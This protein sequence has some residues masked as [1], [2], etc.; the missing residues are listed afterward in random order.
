[1]YTTLA[2]MKVE[3]QAEGTTAQDTRITRCI[4][5]ATAAIDAFCG[6]T[7]AASSTTR[8]YGPDAVDGQ[9]LT[10]DAPLYTL[11]TLT[12][13]DGTAITV[14]D[15]RTD[16]RNDA[17]YHTLILP[18]TLQWQFTDVDSEIAVNGAWFGPASVPADIAEACI[19]LTT[20]L[21]NLRHAPIT[22]ATAM[23]EFGQLIIQKGLPNE[24]QSLLWRHRKV[25]L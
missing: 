16:P 8:R 18:S 12:N 15:V 1:M 23:P 5:A 4:T 14:G 11:T 7:F 10:L 19:K 20:Y 2:V 3:L 17:P 9:R 24:V 25:G 6:R 13:G 21:Y 22:E